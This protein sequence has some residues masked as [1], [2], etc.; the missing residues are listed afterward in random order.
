MA[1]PNPGSPIVPDYHS[2]TVDSFNDFAGYGYRPQATRNGL[3]HWCSSIAVQ[4]VARR[5]SVGQAIESFSPSRCRRAERSQL[6]S[7][8]RHRPTRPTHR[9][10]PLRWRTA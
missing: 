7:N 5:P 6:T 8:W 4:C 9:I 2:G 3:A 10:L 1:V